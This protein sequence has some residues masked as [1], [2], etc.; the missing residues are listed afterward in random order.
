[1]GET[2]TKIVLRKQGDCYKSFKV[3]DENFKT[4][5]GDIVANVTEYPMSG[6]NNQCVSV[7]FDVEGSD[8][9]VNGWKLPKTISINIHHPGTFSSTRLRMNVTS[10]DGL[11]IY[12]EQS[13]DSSVCG[14]VAVVNYVYD[15]FWFTALDSAE[16]YEAIGCFPLAAGTQ[17][18][19]D[20]EIARMTRSLAHLKKIME[21]IK[22][23]SKQDRL[24]MDVATSVD[25][26]Y[27]DRLNMVLKLAIY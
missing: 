2:K 26:E 16:A 11:G 21:S 17:H 24:T 9:L 14:A 7:D 27:N 8:L 22:N 12:F 4:K 23:V 1:M 19:T 3:M 15:A 5:D 13:R 25:K 10:P 6:Y 18:R 20:A